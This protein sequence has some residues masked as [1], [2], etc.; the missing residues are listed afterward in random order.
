MLIIISIAM[1]HRY[2][3]E[4]SSELIEDLIHSLHGPGFAGVAI[5]TFAAL[6][7]Y[8]G[9][10]ANY[11]YAAAISLAIGVLSEI[12]QIPGPRDASFR[13]LFVDSIAIFGGLGVIAI[14]DRELN[15]LIETKTRLLVAS[16]DM[17]ALAISITPTMWYGYVIVEQYR[18]VPSLLSFEHRWESAI[19]G[20][21]Y[22]RKP[23]LIRKPSNWQSPG[24]TIAYTKEAGRW[25]SLVQI[26][27]Y[28]DWTEYQKFSFIASTSDG[29]T[30]RIA[31][32]IRDIPP[33]DVRRNRYH[34]QIDVN[35]EPVK[36]EF[37]L[38]D[39]VKN[40]GDHPVDISHV[41]AVVLSAVGPDNDVALF[42]DNFRLE[43]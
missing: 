29:E 2:S 22:D 28:P 24:N 18:S 43:L 7:S 38:A 21:G 19:F 37:L 6:E 16:A 31:I 10:L 1:A 4:Q 36:Y 20:Q 23:E 14:F 30:H 17:I 35:G 8:R 34:K 12:A 42:I 5:F 27:P 3:P 9:T 40:R 13:D 39:V 26:T 41:G 11:I 15:S 33:E 32:S 25:R